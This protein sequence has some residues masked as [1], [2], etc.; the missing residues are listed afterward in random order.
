MTETI[1]AQA[2]GLFSERAAPARLKSTFAAVWVHQMGSASIPPVIITPD[3]TVDL[4]WFRGSLRVAGPDK[5]AQ[6]EYVGPNEVVI[7]FRFH[8]AAAAG[9][10]GISMAELT[11]QRCLLEDLLERRAQ[12]MAKRVRQ[13]GNIKSLVHSV[14]D[15]ISEVSDLPKPNA[16]MSA[17]YDL[18]KVG[19]PSN[20]HIIPWLMS[21]L[22]MSERT[23]RRNF[24]DTFGYGPKT[25]DRILRYQRFLRLSNQST[26]SV[27][28]AASEAGYSDQAHLIRE[29]R[30][31]TGTTP[32]QLQGLLQT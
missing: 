17:A 2:T 20:M 23:L 6:K 32:R 14:A 3:A 22:D 16:T 12:Q 10:L 9:W 26:V 8:P 24:S 1:P 31:F 19:A 25:L 21:K 30:R 29:C 27:A 18:V 4:Q 15:A 28:N 7:G 13:D 5:E 11:S